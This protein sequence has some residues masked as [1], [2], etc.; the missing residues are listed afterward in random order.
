MSLCFVSVSSR[1][2]SVSVVSCHSVLCVLLSCHCVIVSC[3]C[4]SCVLSL[5]PVCRVILCLPVLAVCHRVLQVCRTILSRC[6]VCCIVL[7]LCCLCLVPPIMSRC[8]VCRLCLVLKGFPFQTLEHWEDEMTT[9]HV[10][11]RLMTGGTRHKRHTGHR[12][13]TVS[14]VSCSSHHKSLSYMSRRHFVFP[15]LKR[16]KGKP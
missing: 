1:L 6:P 7:Q 5:R 3:Y 4:V 9:R 11:Q 15:K 2:A 10:G 8:P 13:A 14:F 16:L 12:L